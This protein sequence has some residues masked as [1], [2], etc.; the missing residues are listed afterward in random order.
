MTMTDAIPEV[1]Q[2]KSTLWRNRMTNLAIL[3]MVGVTCAV[4]VV[5]ALVLFTKIDAKTSHTESD[6]HAILRTVNAIRSA[7][8]A[9]TNRNDEIQNCELDGFNDAFQALQ[10]AFHGDKNPADYP[11]KVHCSAPLAPKKT[12]VTKK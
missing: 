6:D 11:P 7:Q 10:L 8:V 2:A 12:K 9:N 5:G 4:I 1:R 3:I